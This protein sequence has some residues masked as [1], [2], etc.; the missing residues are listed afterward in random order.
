MRYLPKGLRPMDI[1]T[2]HDNIL[3]E[4]SIGTQCQFLTLARFA[5]AHLANLEW[6]FFSAKPSRSRPLPRSKYD[7]DVPDVPD[8]YSFIWRHPFTQYLNFMLFN[9]QNFSKP[10]QR[11]IKNEENYIKSLLLWPT[12]WHI[13]N[14]T[15]LHSGPATHHAQI[16]KHR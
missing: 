8:M 14:Y 1:A 9:T 6:V 4:I 5:L 10:I 12:W 2:S 11:A 3:M 15:K 16:L 7:E 13:M